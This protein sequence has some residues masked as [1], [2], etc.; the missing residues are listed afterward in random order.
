MSRRAGQASGACCPTLSGA[1]AL[2][3]AADGVERITGRRSQAC[4]DSSFPLLGREAPDADMAMPNPRL[5]LTG[6]MRRIRSLRAG[7]LRAAASFRKLVEQLEQHCHE[8]EHAPR[9][10]DRDL[11]D[12]V[13][14][15][16]PVLA[17]LVHPIARV[18]R[19]VIVVKR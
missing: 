11:T 6:R 19:N 9:L 5:H 8:V 12:L 14:G 15:F 2:S 3:V 4:V 18:R 13:V 7:E 16:I 17:D 10:L 1:A